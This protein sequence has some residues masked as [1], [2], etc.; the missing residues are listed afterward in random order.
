M[1]HYM[2]FLH[3]TAGHSRPTRLWQG[4]EL[5]QE[6]LRQRGKRCHCKEEL[7]RPVHLCSTALL[8]RSLPHSAATPASSRSTGLFSRGKLGTPQH[9][10]ENHEVESTELAKKCCGPC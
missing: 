7:Q 4:N 10:P 3:S 2:I 5:R 8:P 1:R 9:S 6:V